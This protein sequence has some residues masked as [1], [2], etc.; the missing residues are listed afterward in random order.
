MPRVLTFLHS[1]EPGGVERIALRLVRAWQQDGGDAPL[2]IGRADGALGPEFDD[3]RRIVPVQPAFGSGWW[4]TLWM[5]LVLPRRIR[6]IAPDILFCAG[7]SY[8]VVAVAM[9]LL[10]GASCPPVV[11]KISND[12][13]RFDMPVPMRWLY[14]RW[15][16][17]QGRLI[18]HFVVM[19]DA[20][21]RPTAEALGVAAQ[22]ISVIANPAL[23]L[24]QIERMRTPGAAV[25][26]AAPG[27]HFA[28]VG[29]L[30]P[31]KDYPMMLRA[32]ARGAG[33]DD[34]LTIYGEGRARAALEAQIARLGLGGRV[35]LAGHVADIERCL[36]R[37]DALLLSSAYEGIPAALLEA[38]AAG[39][40]I[41]ATDCGR[42]IR[43]LL[44]D[45]RLGHIVAP[46]DE[47]GFMAAIAAF[48]P[49]SQ[50]IPGCLDQ[51]R[52]FCVERAASGYAA[53]FADIDSRHRRAARKAA[54]VAPTLK[55]GETVP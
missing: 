1:F 18:D 28:A 49:G 53:C 16:R 34:R 6:A 9:K 37:H 46:G 7:N 26:S 32:F 20:L 23:S 36:P 31:Q 25:R 40:G 2:L 35:V 54:G 44:D 4:E 3:V 11:A 24:G 13:D 17:V 15:L 8:A 45:G 43:A 30:A 12:L 27:R 22:R 19:E 50:D 5:M 38:M 14:H 52:R 10:F 48:V 29:R 21:A 51:A 42:A 33:A 47:A 39:I 41:I 55:G